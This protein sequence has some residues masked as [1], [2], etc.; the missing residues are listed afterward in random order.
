MSRPRGRP[1]SSTRLRREDCASFQV[2]LL[3]N[4]PALPRP[5]PE[6]EIPVVGFIGDVLPF[7]ITLRVVRTARAWL[8]FCPQCGRRAATI[9][10]PPG[11]AEPGCR[12]CLRLVYESQY[13]YLPAWAV[14]VGAVARWYGPGGA[15]L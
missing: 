8:C 2:R 3:P 13:D 1:E 7:S 12:A 15:S 5:N 6:A 10:F 9:Y 14:Y 11:S 4:L